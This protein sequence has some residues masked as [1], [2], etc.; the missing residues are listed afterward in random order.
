MIDK[1]LGLTIS[2]Y[3]N[4]KTENLSSAAVDWGL[5]SE[6]MSYVKGEESDFFSNNFDESSLSFTEFMVIRSRDGSY[7]SSAT[8][9][10][11]SSNVISVRQ[12]VSDAI[13]STSVNDCGV[14]F[15]APIDSDNYLIAS[16]RIHSS[17][18]QKTR[19][20]VFTLG[21]DWILILGLKAPVFHQ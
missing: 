8:W 18:V 1:L 12:S 11:E 5:W 13:A 21:R 9:D 17:T 15:V 3:I 10:N 19:M 4:T 20:V 6:T 16:G 7:H 14:A 2:T